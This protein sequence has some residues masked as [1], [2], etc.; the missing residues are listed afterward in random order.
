MGSRLTSQSKE[1]SPPE[2]HIGYPQSEVGD[3]ALRE[4]IGFI[5]KEIILNRR[6]IVIWKRFFI[7]C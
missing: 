6:S 3:F 4:L 2:I 1:W 7:A 5:Y